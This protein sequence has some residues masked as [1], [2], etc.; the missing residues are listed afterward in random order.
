MKVH[1]GGTKRLWTLT[2]GPGDITATVAWSTPEEV[3]GAMVWFGLGPVAPSVTIAGIAGIVTTLED[4]GNRGPLG[5]HQSVAELFW[6]M[7]SLESTTTVAMEIQAIGPTGKVVVGRVTESP[8]HEV[9]AIRRRIQHYLDQ[10]DD[11]I[12]VWDVVYLIERYARFRG[13]LPFNV[14]RLVR[15]L[16]SSLQGEARGAVQALRLMDGLI[17]GRP[18]PHAPL[19]IEGIE[20]YAEVFYITLLLLNHILL[21]RQGLGSPAVLHN[22]VDE[23]TQRFEDKSVGEWCQIMVNYCQFTTGI[24]IPNPRALSFVS[25]PPMVFFND[26]LREWWNTLPIKEGHHAAN[27]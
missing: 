1:V 4:R 15:R 16:S 23:L 14:D 12:P 3:R 22:L 9:M 10:F 20:G 8:D 19:S 25:S 18:T 11:G 5:F 24:G 17:K 21:Y 6:D 2:T 13:E 7:R 26:H 27:S